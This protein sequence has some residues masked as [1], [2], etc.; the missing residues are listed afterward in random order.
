MHDRFGA[1]Q[2]V[3]I[4]PDRVVVLFGHAGYRVIDLKA[5]EGFLHPG[6]PKLILVKPLTYMNLSGGP[7][8]ALAQFYK[9][10]PAQIIA[11]H[12]ELDIPYGQLRMKIGGG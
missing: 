3:K 9:V 8:S 10:P 1:G 7:V 2:V 11:V 5:A 4:E 12:D 6:G